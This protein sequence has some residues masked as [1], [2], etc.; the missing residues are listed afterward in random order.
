MRTSR[1]A[2]L[3]AIKHL[4]RCEQLAGTSLALSNRDSTGAG[5]GGMKLIDHTHI[6]LVEHHSPHSF[7]LD[8]DEEASTLSDPTLLF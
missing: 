5:N 2:G 7:P 8:S 4:V 3:M 1:F 6:Y